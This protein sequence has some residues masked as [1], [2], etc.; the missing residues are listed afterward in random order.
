MPKTP[1]PGLQRRK[2][3][4]GCLRTRRRACQ[5]IVDDGRVVAAKAAGAGGGIPR[6]GDNQITV[7]SGHASHGR[8]RSVALLPRICKHIAGL[9][10]WGSGK[11]RV[12]QIRLRARR[13]VPDSTHAGKCRRITVSPRRAIDHRCRRDR[14]NIFD[15]RRFV[16]RHLRAEQVRNCN[17]CD[18]QDDC[19]H[20]QELDQREAGLSLTLEVRR[21]EF[22]GFLQGLRT[23]SI[24]S[25]KKKRGG[26]SFL[27]LA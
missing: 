10:V 5:I 2:R 4:T 6:R 8:R 12:H 9:R 22:C 1:L 21:A 16:R 26:D 18:D 27:L 7:E 3:R 13:A 20:D 25:G 11:Y 19:D 23:S 17:R 15:G 24:S 14:T